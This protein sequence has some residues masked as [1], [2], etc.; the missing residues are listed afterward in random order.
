MVNINWGA[1]MT[2]AQEGRLAEFFARVLERKTP[3]GKE[4]IAYRVEGFTKFAEGVF[5]TFAE[6][7]EHLLGVNEGLATLD[8]IQDVAKS[9]LSLEEFLAKVKDCHA[10]TLFF[11]REGEKIDDPEDNRIA[12]RL[13]KIAYEFH[14]AYL[15]DYLKGETK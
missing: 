2:A 1:A 9:D 3:D 7:N 13:Y 14:M 4:K 8:V 5:R 15:K 11:F 10:T 12:T 6:G